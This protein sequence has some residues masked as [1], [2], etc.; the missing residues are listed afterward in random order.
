MRFTAFTAKR[1]ALAA[2]ALASLLASAGCASFDRA[3]ERVV[4]VV[5]P[6][7]IEV[8][9]GNF[10]SREQVSALRAGMSRTQVRDILGTPLITDAFHRDRWDY[11]FTIKRQGVEPQQR[12]LAL[13]FREDA[14]DRFEGDEMPTEAE[15]V[16]TLDNKRRAAR[17]PELE[18]SEEKLRQFAAENKQPPPPEI[19]AAPAALTAYPPLEPAQR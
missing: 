1:C 16:A 7:R 11:V 3:T 12:R 9:Q 13:Y 18:A 4:G 10:V 19:P 6:Y 8:V 15:F 2:A 5:T 17:V 14:L